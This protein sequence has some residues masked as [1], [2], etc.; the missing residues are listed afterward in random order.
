MDVKIIN[1]T[2]FEINNLSI[3]L[4]QIFQNLDIGKKMNII[5]VSDKYMKKVN[6]FYLKK[7]YTTYVL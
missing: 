3:V 6:N 2:N 1:N 4:T 7:N 5:F